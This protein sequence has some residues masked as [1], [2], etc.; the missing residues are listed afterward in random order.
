ML[1]DEAAEDA[2]GEM[3]FADADGAG[4]EQALAG[5]ID[6]IG[7]DKL[8]RGEMGAAQRAIGAAKGGFV[9]VERVMAVALGDAGGGEAALFA[10][11]LL[12]L[13]GAGDPQAAV[14][15]D[16]YQ[17]YAVADCDSRSCALPSLAQSAPACG[18]GKGGWVGGK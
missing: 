16:A 17:T 14:G 4:E 3:G 15:H 5:G 12:A 8:A 18:G 1:L 2:D 10:V 13:A 7:L 11:R 9:A 6:G